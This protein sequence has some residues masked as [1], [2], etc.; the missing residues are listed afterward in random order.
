MSKE[1]K[2]FLI[3]H[4]VKNSA[5]QRIRSLNFRISAIAIYVILPVL[6]AIGFSILGLLVYALVKTP[7]WIKRFEQGYFG[8]TKHIL[9]I[10]EIKR[11]RMLKTLER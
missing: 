4:T 1:Q 5:F 2:C 8:E 3:I 10:D 6:M 9:R 7:K 11:P